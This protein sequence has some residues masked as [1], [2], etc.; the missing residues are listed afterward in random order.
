MSAS[1]LAAGRAQ[2]PE[3]THHILD[4][5]TL[6]ASYRS[7]EVLI[8]PGMTVLDVGCGTG[9]I[10]RGMAERAGPSG[11]VVGIDPSEPLVM[12][13]REKYREVPGLEFIVADVYTYAPAVPFDVV[14][15]ARTLQ[16]LANP[17]EAL[18]RM[19]GFLKPGGILS[20]L[21]YNHE[22]INWNPVPPP[23][24]QLFYDAFLRWRADAGMQNDIADRLAGYFETAG[25]LEIA[26][27]GQSE[28]VRR[29]DAGYADKLGIWAKVAETRGHQLVVDGYVTEAQRQAA[30]QDYTAW[31][32]T[33][34]D[35]MEMYL[36]AVEGRVG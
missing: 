5:R 17:Y 1:S 3:G 32:A 29:T 19:A 31:M 9:A 12:Q 16:W 26:T 23:S 15:S 22:K 6:A 33:E 14:A 24:M 18:Q 36:L 21:D 35:S 27:T 2:M 28:T 25:L 13:A 30:V 34:A 4:Q 7:L 10:T 20:V 11:K 8:K